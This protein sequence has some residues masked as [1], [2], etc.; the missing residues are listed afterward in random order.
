MSRSNPRLVSSL[1][2]SQQAA[3]ATS[4][5]EVHLHVGRIVIDAPAGSDRAALR[6]QIA[7]Q[8]PQAIVG[9]LRSEG[10][11]RDDGASPATPSTV[12]RIAATVAEQVRALV[13]EARA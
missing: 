12:D 5:R 10:P 9:R 7:A 4:P 3:A 8:L 13:A 11:S 2:E 6:R 1:T